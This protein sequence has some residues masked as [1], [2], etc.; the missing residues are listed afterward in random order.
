MSVVSEPA[1]SERITDEGTELETGAVGFVPVLFQSIVFAGP[2]VGVGLSLH[3]A[4]LLELVDDH[5]DRLAGE[6]CP[7]CDHARPRSVAVQMP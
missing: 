4:G 5:R 1:P 7:L 2:A 3:H 6:P